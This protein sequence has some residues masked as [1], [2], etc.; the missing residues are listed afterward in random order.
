MK[1]LFH[2]AL[3]ASLLQLLVIQA[4]AFNLDS[5]STRIFFIESLDR[6]INVGP[7][8]R[9][10]YPIYN[11]SGPDAAHKKLT[12]RPNNSATAG[13]R[14][15]IFGVAMETTFSLGKGTNS[16]SRYG[17]SHSSDLVVNGVGKR[18]YGD[19][20]WL[21]YE[22]LYLKRS[23]EK[24]SAD[25]VLPS[26][27]DMSVR[28]RSL[29]F[30]WI[31]RPD[32]FSLRSAYL[33]TERQIKSS[34]SPL[35]RIN[36]S[37]NK[38]DAD[39]PLISGADVDYFPDLNQVNGIHFTSLGIGVGYSYTYVPKRNFFL[40]G[41]FV[42][43]PA[44]YWSRYLNPGTA[45]TYD[46]QFNLTSYFGF[47]AGYNGDRFYGGF[48]Y[49]GQTFSLKNNT[50]GISGNQNSFAIHGGMRLRETGFLKKRLSDINYRKISSA[51]LK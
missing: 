30:T 4:S 41:A 29:S 15:Y 46:V 7:I 5:D 2:L 31:L 6:K 10:R 43:G 22:G 11:I 34:G 3:R 51:M 9:H 42:A 32:R 24:Y 14:A 25:A 17:E 48:T 39:N 8:L 23:W 1:Q 45:R 27:S 36:L 33:F 40:N 16:V 28:T 49:R 44:H 37:T 19:I 35:L 26:R 13:L 12:F 50:S 21:N 20:Q 18:W 47:S 38:F